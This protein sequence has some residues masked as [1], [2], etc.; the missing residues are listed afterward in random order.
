VLGTGTRASEYADHLLE[1]V[2]A[3]PRS[4]VPVAVLPFAERGEFEGRVLAILERGARRD[5]ASRRGAVTILSLGLLLVAPLAAVA[6][7]RR[8]DPAVEAWP[9]RLIVPD[10]V[11]SPAPSASPSVKLEP[12][13]RLVEASAEAVADSTVVAGRTQEQQPSR[14]R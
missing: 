12:R 8:V 13:P 5:P 7:V 14:S 4:A 10:L 2:R 11:R 3:V 9:A 1:I 6:P